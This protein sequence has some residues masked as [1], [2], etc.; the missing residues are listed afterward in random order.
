MRDRLSLFPLETPLKLSAIISDIRDP[1]AEGLVTD[2]DL[3]MGRAWLGSQTFQHLPQEL[4]FQ[5][6]NGTLVTVH[7]EKG[8]FVEAYERGRRVSL[9]DENRIKYSQS[10]QRMADR[11]LSL[12]LDRVDPSIVAIGVK[13]RLVRVASPVLDALNEVAYWISSWPNLEELSSIDAATVG[14]AAKFATYSLV[15][16][17]KFSSLGKIDLSE[18]IQAFAKGRMTPAQRGDLRDGVGIDLSAPYFV[19]A[20]RNIAGEV[21][22]S[23]GNGLFRGSIEGI[24]I[25][26]INLKENSSPQSMVE[27]LPRVASQE[28]RAG[29]SN[30]SQGLESTQ[31]S[32]YEA[33]VALG[34]AEAL[35]KPDK[36]FFDQIGVF[37]GLAFSS[38][39]LLDYLVNTEL[40]KLLNFS[41]AKDRVGSEELIATL[42]TFLD[43]GRNV[44][45]TARGMFLHRNTL[46]YRLNRIVAIMNSSNLSSKALNN[47]WGMINADIPKLEGLQV[48]IQ[49]HRIKDSLAFAR[50]VC[51]I[52]NP[53]D[54]L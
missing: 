7:D 19:H 46:N 54:L 41:D 3:R 32:T 40:G 30:I 13:D 38:P 14:I 8:K 45:K 5:T 47:S 16:G 20:A 12:E 24:D 35:L 26:A 4:S 33:L 51:G 18:Y 25:Q 49:A 15:N 34:V 44:F 53:E 28:F 11:C 42:T 10:Y 31:K 29:V 50:S 23:W 27:S 17:G 2:F 48:G 52:D 36:V 9:D 37:R 1:E 21:P 43:T 39:K 6:G 22:K